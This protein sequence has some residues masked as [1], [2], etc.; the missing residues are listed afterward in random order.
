MYARKSSEAEDR[1]VASIEA[2]KQELNKLVSEYKLEVVEIFSESRSAKQPGRPVF[3]Q[4]LERIK[5][6]EASG[7]ICWKL[8]R[9]SRNPIDGG[10]IQWLLQQNIIKHIQTF[11]RSYYPT[12]NV[13]MIGVELGMANQY[14][15]DLSV[16]VKRGLNNKIRLGWF[17]GVAPEGYLNT[18]LPERGANTV[19]PDK[20]R[21]QLVRR[22]FKLVIYEGKTPMEVFKILND[23]WGYKTVKRKKIGGGKLRRSVWYRMLTSPFYYG[24][25]EWPLK[26]GNFIKGSHKPMITKEEF[27]RLQ[28]ILGGKGHRLSKTREFSYTSLMVCGECGCAITAEEKNQIICT[29]CKYKFA[30]FNRNECPK[31]ATPIERMKNPTILN[32]V[33]YHCTKKKNVHC[34][35][36]S[37]LVEDLEKQIDDRL[38]EYQINEKYADWAIKHL[39]ESHKLESDT[40][41]SIQESQQTAFNKITK[42]L[43]G[44]LEMR[45]NGEITE[46]EYAQKKSKLMQEKDQYEQELGNTSRRQDEALELAE[47]TFYFVCRSR[48]W[49]QKG[50]KIDKRDVL[51]TL[52]TVLGS[53]LVFKDK[54]L[55]IQAPEP[56]EIIRRSLTSPQAKNGRFEPNKSLVNKKQNAQAMPERLAWLKDWVDFVSVKWIAEVDYPDYTLKTAKKLLALVNT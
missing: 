8:D 18:K 33:Y 41:Q 15:R 7:I 21:F 22:A 54:I 11:G 38:A 30:C 36:G 14:V 39:R 49:L 5:K 2:Q 56:F 29:K 1:Q 45:M 6:G 47:K 52:C 28:I 50:N 12:D 13:L 4:M 53:N 23:K 3:N 34:A 44:L 40:R 32:Y 26:S 25:F 20:Q 46:T 42:Q 43:D 19:V 35:Q 48:T 16:N 31:C 51:K 24:W 10:Q 27:D 37:I 9:L 55:H 17:P